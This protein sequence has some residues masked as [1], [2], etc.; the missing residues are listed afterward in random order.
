ML[1]S[2]GVCHPCTPGSAEPWFELPVRVS[3]RVLVAEWTTPPSE[4]STG[5]WI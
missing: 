1:M 5:G 3:V 2:I 4:S